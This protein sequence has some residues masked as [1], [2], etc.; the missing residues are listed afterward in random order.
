MQSEAPK[1]FFWGILQRS[2]AGSI[3]GAERNV[4]VPFGVSRNPV[5]RGLYGRRPGIRLFQTL[6]NHKGFMTPG[7][8]SKA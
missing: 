8:I 1:H 4:P 2:V 5:V 7:A 6:V 3:V